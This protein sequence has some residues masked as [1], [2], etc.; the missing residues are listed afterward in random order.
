MNWGNK[1]KDYYQ[2]DGKSVSDD[3]N[4]E[5]EEAMKLYKNNA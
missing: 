1:N 2:E 5:E 4:L 3:E